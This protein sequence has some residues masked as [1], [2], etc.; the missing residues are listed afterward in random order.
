MDVP[1]EERVV[2]KNTVANVVSM[3]NHDMMKQEFIEEPRFERQEEKGLNEALQIH[4]TIIH[5]IFGKGI[6][7]EMNGKENKYVIYFTE[8]NYMKLISMSF[9][10]LKKC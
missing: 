4:D 10:G 8:K 9:Q 1:L 5:P 3:S 2:K 7:Q 6:I